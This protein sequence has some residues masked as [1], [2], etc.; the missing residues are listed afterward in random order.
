[1]D[2]DNEQIL[3]ACN[4]LANLTRETITDVETGTTGSQV[5][6]MDLV[7]AIAQGALEG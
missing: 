7:Q 2:S 1:M 5:E 4:Q 3:A 6:A